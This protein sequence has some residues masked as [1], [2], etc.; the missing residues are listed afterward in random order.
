[1]KPERCHVERQPCP[2]DDPR[3]FLHSDKISGP[4]EHEGAAKDDDCGGEKEILRCDPLTSRTSPCRTGGTPTARA[5]IFQLNCDTSGRPDGEVHGAHWSIPEVDGEPIVTPTQ[6]TPPSNS[7]HCT[8]T[9]SADTEHG[10]QSNS[11]TLLVKVGNPPVYPS[12][13]GRPASQTQSVVPENPQRKGDTPRTASGQRREQQA[14]ERQGQSA[15]VQVRA[16]DLCEPPMQPESLGGDIIREHPQ[17]NI[18]NKVG[19]PPDYQL[20][21]HHHDDYAPM[22]GSPGPALTHRHDFCQ[23]TTTP[24]HSHGTDRGCDQCASR[25]ADNDDTQEAEGARN[26][27]ESY[28]LIIPVTGSTTSEKVACEDDQRPQ[29]CPEVAA[30]IKIHDDDERPSFETDR[31]QEAVNI[32]IQGELE[33]HCNAFRCTGDTGSSDDPLLPPLKVPLRRNP[34]MNTLLGSPRCALLIPRAVTLI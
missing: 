8:S 29:K 10:R 32:T 22:L 21:A 30:A 13:R 27:D 6:S 4:I 33:G 9:H 17:G 31:E 16:V 25:H 2:E 18:D 19:S 3:A 28:R 24:T 5:C 1:M 11:P 26:G 12:N 23:H 15:A 34:G 7:A 14:C 20:H